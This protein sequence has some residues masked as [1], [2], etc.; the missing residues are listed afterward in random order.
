NSF[1]KI[2]DDGELSI[3]ARS[4][5]EAKIA[6]KELKLK[7]K[8]Y[9]L[10]KREISQQQK[11]IRAEYTDQVRQRGSKFRGGGSVGRLVRTVQTINR[12]ADRRSLAQE[13]APLEQQKNAVEAVI[14]AI[15]QKILRV[16]RFIVENS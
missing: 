9:A 12:D 16:E 4:V 5:A 2:T 11:Q 8:E 15:D 6:I 13:L 3:S 14:T 10:V 7:K 1:V